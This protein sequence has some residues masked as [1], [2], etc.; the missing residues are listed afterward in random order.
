M[1]FKITDFY[2]VGGIVAA[3]WMFTLATADRSETGKFR[4]IEAQVELPKNEHQHFTFNFRDN[5]KLIEPNSPSSVVQAQRVISVPSDSQHELPIDVPPQVPVT[6]KETTAEHLAKQAVM[7]APIT[8]PTTEPT[9]ETISQQ[10]SKP[11][12]QLI[13]QPVPDPIS[14]PFAQPT[15]EPTIQRQPVIHGQKLTPAPHRHPQRYDLTTETQSHLPAIRA[16]NSGEE[17]SS[18]ERWQRN[19]FA[20]E[21][22]SDAAGPSTVWLENTPPA[23]NQNTDQGNS[24]ISDQFEDHKYP[25]LE[26][27]EPADFHIGVASTSEYSFDS[28][29][30]GDSY[31]SPNRFRNNN[32]FAP[33]TEAN[34]DFSGNSNM[35]RKVNWERIEPDLKLDALLPTQ[36][37]N[38]PSLTRRASHPETEVR[39][40]NAAKH[41][42]AL[43]TRGAYFGAREEFMNALMIVAQSND[44]E[45]GNRAYTTSLLA[46]FTALKE[47][48]DF[49]TTLQRRE[50]SRNLKLVV[51]SHETKVIQP[52]QLDSLSFNKASEVYCQFAQAR[53]EQAIGESK[54]ASSALFHLS[55]I[56]STAPE[57]RG[58]PGVLGD[59]SKRA[60]LL[61]SLTADPKNYEA[62]NELGVLFYKE[63][64]YKPAAHW[65]SMAVEYSGGRQ[66]FWQNL[67]AAHSRLAETTQIAEERS[68]NI[69]LA[70]ISRREAATAPKLE[71]S[72]T[73]LAGWVSPE[74][75]RENSAIPATSFNRQVPV[76]TAQVQQVQAT[77]NQ[78]RNLSKRIKDWFQ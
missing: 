72:E 48:D 63:A 57:L 39:A 1:R 36:T 70:Q 62:A 76:S 22:E 30:T 78:K 31:I 50:H 7:S 60:I 9:T 47:S 41:G 2:I 71:S 58:D 28:P 13:S 37:N 69:R 54:A 40:F 49:A 19:R 43:A 8:E 75:F 77:T 66:V 15:T 21:L 29:A 34:R 25:V 18:K 5:A 35:V 38:F 55:R 33:Q 45:S 74:Q 3:V 32:E 67:A 73:A 51:A 26:D 61:A 42:K 10:T 59:N 64:W 53:I 14:R 44:R 6:K 65:F 52:N 4:P 20:R 11:V 68:E 27:E 56:L 24:N 46:G 23:T 16:L 17:L 12:L